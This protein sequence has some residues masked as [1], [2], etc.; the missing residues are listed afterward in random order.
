MHTR[1]QLGT[2]A[3]SALRAREREVAALSRQL[4]STRKEEHAVSAQ[5]AATEEAARKLDGD[6]NAMRS[7]LA[8]VQASLKARD[9]EVARLARQLDA[10]RGGESEVAARA[11]A[12]ED[13]FGKLDA[14]LS[15]LRGQLLD[16]QGALRAQVRGCGWGF[17]ALGAF[18]AVQRRCVQRCMFLCGE[19]LWGAE[20]VH[21]RVGL[22][23]GWCRAEH[24]CVFSRRRVFGRGGGGPLWW[25]WSDVVRAC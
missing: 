9:A 24:A 16:L 21:G 18:K 6:L 5:A 10:S 11:A 23:D 1:C 17:C 7:R 8:S 4:D 3:E 12:T 25:F 22:R 14:D 19:V 15:A 2:Q 13:A 20:T